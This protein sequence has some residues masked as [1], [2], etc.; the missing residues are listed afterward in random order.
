MTK[1]LKETDIA[2]LSATRQALVRKKLRESFTEY[3]TTMTT[4]TDSWP[5]IS[6]QEFIEAIA[7]SLIAMGEKRKL[8][9]ALL[10]TMVYELQDRVN[11]P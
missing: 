2:L 10:Q 4:S 5:A 7:D 1:S 8:G 6:D 11:H 3:F 9:A